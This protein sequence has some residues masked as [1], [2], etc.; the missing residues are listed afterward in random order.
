MILGE[1]IKEREAIEHHLEALKSRLAADGKAS[2]PVDQI[3]EEIQAEVNRQRVLDFG[4]LKTKLVH[5]LS[6]D[7]SI[8]SHETQ[9]GII[10]KVIG[11][12][13]VLDTPDNRE[14]L[15]ELHKAKLGLEIVLNMAYW[16]VELQVPKTPTGGTTVTTSSTANTQNIQTEEVKSPWV[17]S[18]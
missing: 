3:L 9:L 17:D 12:L 16:T 14:K 5:K 4:I 10:N 6:E 13:S 2:L 7:G 15:D 1:A 8:F 11:I 18:S